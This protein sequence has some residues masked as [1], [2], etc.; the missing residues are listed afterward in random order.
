MAKTLLLPVLL[1]LGILL[2][3]CTGQGPTQAQPNPAQN[4]TQSAPQNGSGQAAPQTAQYGDNATVDYTLRVDGQV[5]DTTFKDVAQ[6]GGIYNANMTYQ[7]MTFQLITGQGLIPGFVNNIIG[8]NVGQ[9][10]NFS[11]AP[12]DAYGPVNDSLI[13]NISRYYNATRYQ[14]VPM[15]YFTENNITVTPGK[16]M[17]M[18]VGNVTIYN[19]TKDN[20]TVEY[21]LDAGQ[22][23]S[24][25]GL[26]QEVVKVTNDTLYIRF[27][28]VANQTYDII[29]QATGETV[30]ARV[31]YADNDTIEMDENSPLAGKTLDFE[32]TLDALNQ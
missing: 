1:M 4:A 9:S 13:F 22:K 17:Q 20:V 26:P 14:V 18:A 6:S 28:M 7:P 29:D 30:L 27:D 21:N 19:A 10:K 12:Q 31:D 32:V 11:V 23:F 2:L 5:V 25:A 24:Q 8:M 15:S 3:G 16:V